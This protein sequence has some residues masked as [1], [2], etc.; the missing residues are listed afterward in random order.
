MFF[1]RLELVPLIDAANPK[2]DTDRVAGTR[3]LVE[4]PLAHRRLPTN[5]LVAAMDHAADSGV[6]DPQV[7]LI[8][9][10]RGQVEP[11]APAISVATLAKHEISRPVLV[12]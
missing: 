10:R 6:L 5:V 8:D 2:R 7:V 12:P 4:L 1:L 9:A 3:A 11:V